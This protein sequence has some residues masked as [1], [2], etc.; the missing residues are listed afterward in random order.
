[1][2]E[3]TADLFPKIS[4]VTGQTWAGKSAVVRVELIDQ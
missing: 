2:D 3:G 1:M 4:H